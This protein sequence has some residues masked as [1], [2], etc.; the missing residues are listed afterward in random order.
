MLTRY[1]ERMVVEDN[2]IKRLAIMIILLHYCDI[3]TYCYYKHAGCD[4][5]NYDDEHNSVTTSNDEEEYKRR[6]FKTCNI[7]PV[8]YVMLRYESC[9]YLLYNIT[10]NCQ[11]KSTDS[12]L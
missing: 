1:N 4:D 8:D 2:F 7:T 10:R 9:N 11:I 12:F 5:A 3:F 6:R